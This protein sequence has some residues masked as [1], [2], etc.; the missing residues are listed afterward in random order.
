MK[1]ISSSGS[2]TKLYPPIS[3]MRIML[4]DVRLSF[5]RSWANAFSDTSLLFAVSGS[6]A[7]LGKGNICDKFH[8]KSNELWHSSG[9]MTSFLDVLI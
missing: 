7:W 3:A 1:M 5:F 4:L 8:L 6:Q 9:P 2:F